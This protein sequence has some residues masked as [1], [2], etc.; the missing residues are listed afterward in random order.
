MAGGS[1]IPLIHRAWKSFSS[2]RRLARSVL[3][4]AVLLWTQTVPHIHRV[5]NVQ[6]QRLIEAQPSRLA[7]E[8]TT[9]HS[10]RVPETSARYLSAELTL[11]Q[12]Y[13]FETSVESRAGAGA[14]DDYVLERVRHFLRRHESTAEQG[15]NEALKMRLVRRH[16]RALA[17]EL[18]PR[19][20]CT[21]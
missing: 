13:E 19:Q 20:T 4:T 18:T 9:P 6:R 21:M 15:G 7:T 12:L 5:V 8:K 10:R 17:F 1:S 3:A 11:I 14:D 2:I 16:A